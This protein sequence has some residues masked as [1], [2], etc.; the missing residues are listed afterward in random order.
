MQY[1]GFFMFATNL[2]ENHL[3]FAVPALCFLAPADR[4]LWPV[5]AIV[6]LTLLQNMAFFDPPVMRLLDPDPKVAMALASLGA[7]LNGVALVIAGWVF[8]V[9]TRR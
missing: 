9:R 3:Y 1:L 7:A 6:S 2:H 5:F 4:R 8:W